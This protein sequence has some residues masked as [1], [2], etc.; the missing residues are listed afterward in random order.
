[1]LPNLLN[2]DVGDYDLRALKQYLVDV[3]GFPNAVDVTAPAFSISTGGTVGV[4]QPGITLPS[5]VVSGTLSGAGGKVYYSGLLEGAITEAGGWGTG[6]ITVSHGDRYNLAFGA[7]PEYPDVIVAGIF[8]EGAGMNLVTEGLLQ[9]Y[10]W[11]TPVLGLGMP[12]PGGPNQLQ[13]VYFDLRHSLTATIGTQRAFEFNAVFSP[14]AGTPTDRFFTL[15]PILDWGGIPGAGS[16]EALVIQAIETSIPTGTNYL[17]RALA[18]ATGQSQK[19]A[20]DNAGNVSLA[21]GFEFGELAADM[22]AGPVGTVRLYA[23][24]NGAGKTEL[25]GRFNTGVP[26]VIL[27]EN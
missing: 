11:Y 12:G 16:Y 14:A 15:K 7:S 3:C 4:L 8:F 18:G 20:V 9:F 19:F 22:P 17:I 23:V 10:T 24:R 26:Q 25:R 2:R 1:M 13:Q 5:P 6:R 27:T 21:G